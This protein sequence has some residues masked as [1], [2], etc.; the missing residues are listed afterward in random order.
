MMETELIL[1]G[2]GELTAT[3]T[4]SRILE[5]RIVTFGEKGNTSAGATI[6]ATN[7]ISIDDVSKIKLTNEHDRTTPIGRM[8]SA[9]VTAQGIDATFKIA[10]TRA[11]DDA[12]MNASEGLKTGFSVGVVNATYER[13]SDH[14]RIVKSSLKDVGHCES[15]AIASSTIKRVAASENAQAEQIP[16]S[17]SEA[18]VNTPNAPAET[19][20]PAESTAP[21]ADAARVDASDQAR[22]PAAP[23][24]YGDGVTSVRSPI[25]S[26]GQ[27]LMHSVNARLRAD[28]PEGR[29]SRDYIGQAESIFAKAFDA[30]GAL[31][32]DAANDSFT[33]NPAFKPVQ[34]MNEFITNTRG[35][36][37]PTV[38]A[39]G[40]TKPLPLQ[41]MTFSIPKLTTAPDVALTTEGQAVQGTTG[42]V[43]AYL[44]GTKKKYAGT[45]IISREIIDNGSDSP[46]FYSELMAEMNTAYD[47]ATNAALIAEIVSSGTQG[48][49]QAGTVAGLQAYIAAESVDAYDATSYF[50]R[51]LVTGKS[52]WKALLG[53]K[54]STGRPI[55]NALQPMNAG[56]AISGQSQ[57]GNVDGLDFYVDRG[58]VA[59]AIDDSAFVI[60]PETI[61][62][63]ESARTF[64][65]IQVL[66]TLEVQVAV[67]AYFTPLVKLAAG[68]R[69]FNL[70]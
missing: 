30:D 44:T 31:A 25:Q 56:G 32:I 14:I 24:P 35:F 29:A 53:E 37:R 58:M 21:A 70:T 36:G 13:E 42:M 40:G 15:P 68:L 10:K 19:S 33:T 57:N 46:L 11:G 62:V 1:F 69:R 6:F 65:E 50:A 47:N 60:A 55:Y 2:N 49:T 41:G 18:S 17:E 23:V 5:G 22:R 38:M 34:Y 67:Y 45:Q 54:D 51:S 59:T 20:A 4:E 64:L 3:D 61:G 48:A 63:Y 12:L 28:T 66:P 43:T 27:Y 52:W 26:T 39:C 8:I 7:S 9:R 16:N